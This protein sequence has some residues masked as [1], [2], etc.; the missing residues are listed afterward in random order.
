MN[1]NIKVKL[2]LI[3]FVSLF[4]L[5]VRSAEAASLRYIRIGEHETFTRIVFE[6]HGPVRFKDPVIKGRGKISVVFLDTTTALP[7]QILSEA[8]K[9]VDAIEF[10][11]QESYLTAQIALSFPY[12][13]LKSFSLSNPE[14]VVLDVSRMSTPPKDVAFQESVH[15]KPTERVLTQPAEKKPTASPERPVV[16]QTGKHLEKP[17]KI[18]NK[19][20]MHG[21]QEYFERLPRDITKQ[22]PAQPK[23]P[24]TAV[25]QKAS[26]VPAPEDESLPPSRRYGHLEI[27]LLAI[28]I[29]LSIIIIVLLTFIF[30]QKR[31]GLDQRHLGGTLDGVL[32]A[33][34]TIAA[35]D[36]RIKD[37]FKK[38]DQS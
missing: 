20:A 9:R 35:I 17:S 32:K 21:T 19:P 25:A 10:I 23:E 22:A 5:Q 6:F 16:G 31:H 4:L 26:Q 3:G 33:N 8:T 14:R 12:F 36:V 30:F 11:Q 13:K 38:Y 15:K 27:Y 28:L 37:E 24:K 1:G 34:E 2:T 7:R 29:V 18:L